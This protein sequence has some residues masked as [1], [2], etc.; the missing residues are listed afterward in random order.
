MEKRV[1]NKG[2]TRGRKDESVIERLAE[3]WPEPREQLHF[4]DWDSTYQ[5][6]ERLNLLNNLLILK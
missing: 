6:I 2:L 4:G 5:L 3:F 1:K